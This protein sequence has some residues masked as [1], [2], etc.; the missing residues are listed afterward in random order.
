M[1]WHEEYNDAIMVT[2]CIAGPLWGESNAHQQKG[3]EWFLFYLN[4][5][6]LLNK[7]AERSVSGVTSSL[8][9][10]RSHI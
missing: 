10:G 7:T 8:G 2:S 6:K 5:H 4:L 9:C 3:A 1:E